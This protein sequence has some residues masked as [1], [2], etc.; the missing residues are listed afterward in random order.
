M[1]QQI[2]G[3][4]KILRI[5]DFALLGMVQ[6]F[7][8]APAFNTQD[9]FELGRTTK[10][11]SAQE[12]ETNGSFEVLSIG[13]TP[14]LLA[15]MLVERTASGVFT[16]Y[17]YDQGGAGGKNAY[18]ITEADLTEA[19]F[20][21][22]CHERSNQ[23][24]Y[25]R[26]TV[27]PRCFLTSIAGRAEAGG[28]ASETFNFG[29]DFVVGMPDP[30]HDV[31]AIPAVRTTSS[32]ATMA[33]TS[34]TGYTL[35][36]FYIDERRLRTTNTDAVYATMSN[37]GVVTITGMTIPANAVMRAIVYKTVPGST[38][39]VLNDSDRTT[40]SFFT[41]GW[42]ASIYI[43]P[44]D[45]ENPTADEQWLR[46]QSIDWNIDMRVEALRQI[47]YNAAGTAIYCRL[48]TLPF[49]ITANASAYE[50]DWADWRAILDPTVKSFPGND[51]YADTYDLA[52]T[53]IQGTF[54]LVIIYYTKNGT[55]L[56]EWRFTDMVLDGRGQRVVVQG[57]AE[58]NWSFRGTGF[59]L[60]GYNA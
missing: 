42:Q 6:S 11:A 7:D 4:D 37:A 50:S 57:R 38:F 1:G 12:L 33:D 25:D 41:Q 10:V 23:T 40:T 58:I 52:V 44:A 45:E 56:Q 48:P 18:T 43:A 19:S 3:S 46:V 14:G 26:S 16:G 54:N 24:V 47:A 55:K 53:S 34:M 8:W 39:P 13:G 27:L 30:Y 36:Y 59:T 20:D 32:T 15:R 22:I 29:G 31:R 60:E 9:I 28:Q 5:N 51:K 49:N 17:M 21:I 35:L 2:L